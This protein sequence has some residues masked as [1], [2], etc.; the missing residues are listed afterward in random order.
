MRPL[1]RTGRRPNSRGVK[2]AVLV[3]G[4]QHDD[5]F[6][7]EQREEKPGQNFEEDFHAVLRFVAKPTRWV[8]ELNHQTQRHQHAGE[9]RREPARVVDDLQD[10]ALVVLV[11]AGL[12]IRFAGVAQRVVHVDQHFAVFAGVGPL[13]AHAAGKVLGNVRAR[14]SS[15]RNSTRCRLNGL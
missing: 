1:S 10:R 2:F 3:F 8:R 4:K 13:Q 6:R 12:I 7:G 15:C 5:D 9:I 14:I 11:E